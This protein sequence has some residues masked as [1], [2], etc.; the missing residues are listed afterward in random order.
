M[1]D[2]R[3]RSVGYL[4][5]RR[6]ATT[7]SAVGKARGYRAALIPPA[8]ARRDNT[9]VIIQFFHHTLIVVHSSLSKP[10]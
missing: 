8:P 1:C 5:T 7:E 10:Y 4:V 9:L 2:R 6:L 3:E